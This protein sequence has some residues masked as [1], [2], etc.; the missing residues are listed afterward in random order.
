M[1]VNMTFLPRF[2]VYQQTSQ[3]PL[4]LLSLRSHVELEEDHVSILHLVVASLLLQLSSRLN[5]RLIAEFLEVLE[6]VHF[7]ADESLL[8]VGVDHASGLGS[9]GSATD[10]P[11]FHL[12]GS[13]GEEVD[14]VQHVVPSGD[15]LGHLAL[16]VV[17]G[18]V[19]GGLLGRHVHQ[20]ALELGAEGNH[21]LLETHRRHLL[22]H[23]VHPTLE[24]GT[25]KYMGSLRRM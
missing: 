10:G 23:L 8:E 4:L 16:G 20:L 15:D 1:R 24:R 21:Q 6:L 17:L 18:A 7:R 13:G 22:A 3:T 25:R 9:Q 14:E 19:L 12:V 5:G 2:H 11:A